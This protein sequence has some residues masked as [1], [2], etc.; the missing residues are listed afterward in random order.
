M[1]S[2]V[3]FLLLMIVSL[4]TL[5]QKP[6]DLDEIKVTPPKFAGTPV[7]VKQH[8]YQS[9]ESYL[10]KYIQSKVTSLDLTN[11]GTVVM[12]FIVNPSGN[13]SDFRVINSVSPTIDNE[14]KKA[15]LTT[16]GMWLP[17]LN[18][19]EQVAMEK[20]ISIA[21][22][23]ENSQGFGK[24]A[25]WYYKQGGKMLYVR[26]NPEKALKRF[27]KGIALRP[28]EKCLLLGR[29]LAKFEIGDKDGACKD[30]NRIKSLGGF[31]SDSF[32]NNFC[33]MEGFAE[34]VKILKE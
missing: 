22:R 6:K 12:Q 31:E 32:L 29:G 21:F 30:W 17:G 19:D 4:V 1:K 8:D 34:L 9:I 25:S 10:V 26:E 16:N 14:V 23:L 13:L 11:E 28:N 7:A 33:E 2:T 15:L 5:G 3:L 18:N 24:R 27:D 20:E